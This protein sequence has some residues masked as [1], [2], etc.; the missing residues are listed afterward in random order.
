MTDFIIIGSGIGG[1]STAA[2]LHTQGYSTM[3]FEKEPY[4]GG[5]SSTFTHGGFHYN[6]GATTFVGYQK[7]HQ[8]K[9]LFDS[10]GAKPELKAVDPALCV[11]H[12]GRKVQ[13]YRDLDALIKEVEEA[14]PLS[15]HRE[16]WTRVFELNRIFYTFGGHYYSGKSLWA[17]VRSLVSYVPLGWKFFPHLRGNALKHIQKFYPQV[18]EAY[19]DFLNAQL[20]IVAQTTLD[21][22]NFLTAA[23]ALGYT[24]NENHYVVGGMG[25]LF[26]ALSEGL[27]SVVK[28]T[29][30]QKIER[31]S[32]HYVVHT[33]HQTYQAKNIVLNGTLYDNHTLF[34]DDRVQEYYKAYKHLNNYQSAFVLYMTVRTD[35]V[36]EHHYQIIQDDVIPQTLSKA[37]FVSISDASDHIIAPQGYRSV[38]VSVHTDTRWWDRKNPEYKAKKLQL[39]EHM[40]SLVCETLSIDVACIEHCFSATP[41]TFKRYIKREQLGGNPVSIENIFFR[42][43]S[44]NTPIDGLYQ[45]GD[46]VYPAQGWPGVVMGSYNLMTLLEKD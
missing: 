34:E 14:Y 21:K 32:D 3:L 5:C 4:L 37:L 25:R 8:V 12:K 15:G 24:F 28:H 10:V 41:S 30:V 20:M 1:C 22:V 23:L 6:A 38:T 19:L 9:A 11:L 27:P 18:S 13:R 2:L 16:F 26:D 31:L 44:N 43:P 33:K 29:T 40:K 7:G 46:S 35:Q 17:K 42:L 45:V 36:L 39:Q